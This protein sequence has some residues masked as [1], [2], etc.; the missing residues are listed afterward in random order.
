LSTECKLVDYDCIPLKLRDVITL[1][2]KFYSRRIKEL[3][4]PILLN[5]MPLFYIL[6]N[7]NQPL[8]FTDI[9]KT[10]EISK[11][12]LSEVINKYHNMGFVKKIASTEDK[13]SFSVVLTEEG[14]KIR[15]QLDG[16]GDEL[17]AKFYSNFDS[18]T[19]D[20]FEKNVEDIISNLN[21]I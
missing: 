16:M 9:F 6:S 14:V 4:L 21:D 20:N 2:D 19:R 5:H 7:S 10:W 13:R 8:A 1:T 11:S 17:I 15:E 12:S 3:G 18:A